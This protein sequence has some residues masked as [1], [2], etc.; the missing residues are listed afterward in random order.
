MTKWISVKDKLPPMPKIYKK[1]YI[2]YGSILDHFEVM[3][4]FFTNQ[5]EWMVGDEWDLGVEVTHWMPM[6]EKPDV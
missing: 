6:P 2:V 5:G 3:E 4:A 1:A